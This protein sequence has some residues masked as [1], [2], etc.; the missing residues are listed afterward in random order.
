MKIKEIKTKSFSWIHISKPKRREISYLK[1]KY[2]FHPL[3]LEDCLVKIQRPQISEYTDHMFFI[4]TFP[5]Y[6]KITKEIESSEIDF[7]ISSKYL[8]T[9]SD[10]FIPVVN[11]FFEDTKENEYNKDKFMSSHPIYL[12]YEIL[13]RLQNY[14]FPMLD[15]MTEDIEAVEKKIFSGKEKEVVRE[16]LNIKRN[17]VNFRKVM[18]AHKNI[19]Q[20]LMNT[21]T[22]FFMPDK[23]NIY[24]SNILDRTKDIWD[25][26]QTQK[27]NI[28]AF[29][30]TN[31]ALLS[32]KLN[33]IMRILT[34][35]S[36]ILIPANLIASIFGMN[37]VN[38]PFVGSPND[39]Y[40]VISFMF[41]ILIFV[42][43]FFKRKRW[44]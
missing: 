6:N 5:V 29:Q 22:K 36:V 30:E 32:H 2:D 8:I 37:V 44:L 3:D 40:K 16:I 12:L 38:A 25:I 13:N 14:T 9:L 43:F 28:N 24:L 10:E 21:R 35:I 26:L 17:T 23:T 15:H 27:E 11:N 7:F 4:L 41:A 18:Q 1:D 42:V 19:I 33:E 31:D 39:F 20:K 34:V